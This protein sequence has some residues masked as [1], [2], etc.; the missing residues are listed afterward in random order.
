M[1]RAGTW[2]GLPILSLKTCVAQASDVAD[3]VPQRLTVERIATLVMAKEMPVKSPGGDATTLLRCAGSAQALLGET[4][5]K[6]F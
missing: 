5:R 4:W 3:G 1:E 6:S 2:S